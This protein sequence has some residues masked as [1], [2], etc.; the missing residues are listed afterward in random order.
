MTGKNKTLPGI[1]L[2]SELYEK[3]QKTL[4]MLNSNDDG[5][6]FDMATIRRMSFSHFCEK[7]LDE[8]LQLDF[9]TNG[10]PE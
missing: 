8:G 6:E 7:V 2:S 10:I 4:E 9:S 1:R 5:I 3:M